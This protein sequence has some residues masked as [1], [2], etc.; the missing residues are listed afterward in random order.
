MT[1]RAFAIDL[2]GTLLSPNEEVS[3]ANQAA[4]AAAR[5][6]GMKIIIATAGWYQRAQRVANTLGIEGPAIACSGAEVRRIPEGTDLMDVRLPIDFARALYEI[7]DNTRCIAWAALDK[8]TA[9][10]LDGPVD[11]SLMPPEMVHV[12]HLGPPTVAPR[13]VLVQ[14]TQA[15]KDIVDALCLNWG[16]KVRFISSFSGTGKSLLTL[17]ATAAH[18]GT[19]LKVACDDLGIQIADVVAMGDAD[20]DLEM[21]AV[22]GASFA[23]GQADDHVKE[24]ATAITGTCAEDGVA[25]AIHRVLAGDLPG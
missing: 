19:A 16:E 14:G 11:A 18:K 15:T 2:D 24:C 21:F 1:F 25:Q 7:C 12:A 5:A 20:N 3:Q 8:T 9:M 10:K 6:A 22:A 23:M 17:T 13:M 4:V